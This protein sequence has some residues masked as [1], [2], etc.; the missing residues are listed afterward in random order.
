MS[1]SK[2]FTLRYTISG[3][4]CMLTIRPAETAISGRLCLDVFGEKIAIVRGKPSS[5]QSSSLL[6]RCAHPFALHLYTL[7]IAVFRLHPGTIQLI[8]CLSP[9]SS[10]PAPLRS[11]TN[12][13]QE[14]TITGYQRRRGGSTKTYLYDMRSNVF[15]YKPEI[16]S[17]GRFPHVQI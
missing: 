11:R 10:T 12:Y 17:L 13:R 15:H 3:S 16:L 2:V 4:F 8:S 5:L 7:R 9:P 14:K 1:P 6:S